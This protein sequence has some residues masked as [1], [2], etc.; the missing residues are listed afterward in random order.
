MHNQSTACTGFKLFFILCGFFSASSQA[1]S[2]SDLLITEVM[3]N[4]FQ[5]SDSYGE[6]FELYNPTSDFINLQGLILRDGGTNQHTISADA[7]LNIAPGDYFVMARNGDMALNGG[8]AVDYVYSNFTLANTT[9][10]IIFSD[11]ISDLLRL[12]YTGNFA[13]AGRS[14]E[15]I[16]LPMD[17]LNFGLT[18][19]NMVY[20]NGDIGTPGTAGSVN[21]STSPVPVPAAGWLFA[22]GLLGLSGL[23]RSG[24]KSN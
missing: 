4:P 20:G 17:E 24:R 11:G 13:E 19:I 7:P 9:D 10:Q 6:W 3:A 16:S 15:L 12:D 14:M 5:V 23:H 18:E 2:V 8:L 21:F 1:S 22:G